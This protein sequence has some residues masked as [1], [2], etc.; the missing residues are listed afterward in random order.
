MQKIVLMA[1]TAASSLAFL[2]PG[3]SA[4]TLTQRNAGLWEV[5]SER[6]SDFSQ[7]MQGMLE[8]VPEAQREQ[9]MAMLQQQAGLGGGKHTEKQCITQAMAERERQFEP[10][11]DADMKCDHKFVV[12]S[13]SEAA[14]T[15]SCKGPEGS[16]TGEGRVWDYSATHYKSEMQLAG[17][18]DG[19]PVKMKHSEQ[20]NWL[21]ADCQGVQPL[22]D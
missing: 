21:G 1:L 22:E 9:M 10:E 11:L 15:F 8:Q 16:M 13:S 20:G 18:I 4:Q 17:T 7:M 3:A 5:Q 19:S 2:A 12:R 14:Y 6:Q